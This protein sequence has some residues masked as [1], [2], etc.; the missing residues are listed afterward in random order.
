MVDDRFRFSVYTDM[1]EMT[2]FDYRKKSIEVVTKV[3][4][5]GSQ[6][7]KAHMKDSLIVM[8][9]STG[10][11]VFI[12]FKSHRHYLVTAKLADGVSVKLLE[13][14]GSNNHVLYHDSQDNTLLIS[15][16][17]E[18]S[19]RATLDFSISTQADFFIVRRLIFEQEV[20]KTVKFSSILEGSHKS[21]SGIIRY[22]LDEEGNL[23]IL[24]LPDTTDSKVAGEDLENYLRSHHFEYKHIYL[25][26]STCES[27]EQMLSS[28][29]KKLEVSWFPMFSKVPYYALF[30]P[31]A[32]ATSSTPQRE[33]SIISLFLD[34]EPQIRQDSIPKLHRPSAS[35][36]DIK[37][38]VYQDQ[39]NDNKND[40]EEST[41]NK[42]K[43]GKAE[44]SPDEKKESSEASIF[45]S[46]EKKIL[47]EKQYVSLTRELHNL[48][49]AVDRI[50]D[51]SKKGVTGTRMLLRT[52]AGDTDAKSRTK[53]TLRGS[54]QTAGDPGKTRSSSLNQPG[55]Q[56]DRSRR[57]VSKNKSFRITNKSMES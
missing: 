20:P 47:A 56:T 32:G 41:D 38:A 18:Y 48:V 57:S 10:Y 35:L 40:N 26:S 34:P 9:T 52:K 2:C 31:S 54:I 7:M 8:A 12:L 55:K 30:L 43:A 4:F 11:L 29:T 50:S 16:K 14:I 25:P 46:R 51:N 33:N 24:K 37:L 19:K 44:K 1:V 39:F 27:L 36:V 17:E 22:L 49:R 5:D 3:G 13:V 21:T 45:I 23:Y 53:G 6:I 15:I 42:M 28:P